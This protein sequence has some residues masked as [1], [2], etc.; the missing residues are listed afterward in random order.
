MDGPYVSDLEWRCFAVHSGGCRLQLRPCLRR[1]V[2]FLI[3][4][5]LRFAAKRS[6][7]LGTLAANA[8]ALYLL[9]YVF[10][11]WLQYAL[12]DT[13]LPAAIKWTIVFGL[14]LLLTWIAA[15]TVQRVPLGARLIGSPR[16]PLAKFAP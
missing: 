2:F 5:S 8:Y 9:H 11:V 16:H 15:T 10:V 6:R 4:V 13:P 3:A 14:T 7:I 12:L 1:G